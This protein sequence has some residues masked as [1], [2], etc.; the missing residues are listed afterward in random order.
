MW[1]NEVIRR[2]EA[3]HARDAVKIVII[4]GGEEYPEETPLRPGDKVV[5]PGP[6]ACSL[7]GR[8]ICH[9]DPTEPPA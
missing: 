9:L 4:H 8:G 2:F 6:V 7:F 3:I 5:V 1:H